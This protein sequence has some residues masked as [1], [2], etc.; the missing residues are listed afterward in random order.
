[1][2]PSNLS[3]TPEKLFQ[4][5]GSPNFGNFTGPTPVLNF[6]DFDFQ[7]LHRWPWSMD[8]NLAAKLLKRW[9]FVGVMD[10][11][12]VI[13]AAVVHLNYVGSGFAYCY[14]KRS[15]RIVEK[16]IKAPFCMNTSFSP[17]AQEGVSEI[18]VGTSFIRM[19]NSTVNGAREVEMDFGPD[20]RAKFSYSEL[21]E[22]VSTC[23]RQAMY[24]F[25]YTYKS[26][27]LP[28]KG[29]VTMHGEEI[30]LANDA[31]ALLDWSAATPPRVTVWNWAAG[32]GKDKQGKTV[33]INFSSGLI[34]GG[35]N[36]NT[37]WV[38]GKPHMMDGVHFD[39]DQK[40]VTSRPWRIT[41]N[42][43]EVD[44]T[45]HPEHERYEKVNFGL[46]ASSLHQPF[47]RFEGAIKLGKTKLAL[48]C[49]G[50]CEEHYAKW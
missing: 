17:S 32:M 28:A 20:L 2:A 39:Y 8:A 9:E 36:E 6:E 26:A 46:V 38:D 16:N 18:R 47:G 24:G 48:D 23:T 35:Y 15:Q 42:N 10:E 11:N 40:D 41:S 29:S 37:V 49:Y 5:D 12:F 43:K 27:A 50:F 33:G 30:P 21:G 13:G 1:M 44:I 3:K 4:P 25:G 45:F 7:G 34:S 22:G 19:N 31:L 14:D